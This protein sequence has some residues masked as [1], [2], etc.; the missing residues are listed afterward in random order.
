MAKAKLEYTEKHHILEVDGMEYEVPA[1][2]SRTGGK[3]AGA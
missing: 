1:A 3:G 2:H